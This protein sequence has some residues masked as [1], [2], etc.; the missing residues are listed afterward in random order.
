MEI[1]IKFYSI[2]LPETGNR[3]PNGS[4]HIQVN[5]LFKEEDKNEFKYGVMLISKNYTSERDRERESEEERK[6]ILLS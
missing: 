5:N 6:K 4:Q 1:T 2:D 3:I